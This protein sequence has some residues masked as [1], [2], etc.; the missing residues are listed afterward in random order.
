[1]VAWKLGI[2]L[3]KG[4]AVAWRDTADVVVFGLLTL[5]SAVVAF[6]SW[7]DYRRFGSSR[8]V[9]D[10][11]DVRPGETLSA[12]LEAAARLAY[13]REV[14]FELVEMHR[15]SFDGGPYGEHVRATVTVPLAAFQVMP[16]LT[17]I[18]ASLP[19]PADGW[20]S[21]KRKNLGISLFAYHFIGMRETE[22]AWEV[23]AAA[24]VEGAPYRARF[25]VT[26]APVTPL[27]PAEPYT[28]RSIVIP[29]SD[30]PRPP[31]TST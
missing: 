28:P 20:A 31:S 14:R 1:M 3:Q 17:R 11:P 19:V 30:K 25:R 24:E 6:R 9:P 13:A 23:R 29:P 21:F 15:S 10:G 5:I 16:G 18:P 4:S 22:H 27:E 7:S 26:V 12:T 8:L 2:W